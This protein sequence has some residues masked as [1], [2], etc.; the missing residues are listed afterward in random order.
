MTAPTSLGGTSNAEAKVLWNEG[1]LAIQKSRY[2]EAA[3]LLKRYVDRYPGYPNS[4]KAKYYLGQA[5]FKLGKYDLALLELQG[6]ITASAPSE[7]SARARLLQGDLYLL[8][9]DFSAAYLMT[10]DL[11]QLLLRQKSEELKNDLKLRNL[12]LKANALLGLKQKS[13]LQLALTALESQLAS[14]TS[15]EGRGIAYQAQLRAKLAECTEFPSQKDLKESQIR[16]QLDRRGTC[17]LEA[18]QNYRQVLRNAE[19]ESVA[20]AGAE[21]TAAFKSYAAICKNPN[22]AFAASDSDA[23]SQNRSG[24]VLQSELSAKLT[25]ECSQKWQTAVEFLDHWSTS[26][27]PHIKDPLKNT[28]NNLMK[29]TR[30]E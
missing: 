1:E 27:P 11:D 7:D 4:L 24:R 20:L 23:K 26:V 3:S 2:E 12:A 29:L 13:R 16:D 5:W 14:V 15:A 28:T 21:M 8:K 22:S 9:G 19:P 17:L 25:A 10:Y 6:F 30:K 18:L